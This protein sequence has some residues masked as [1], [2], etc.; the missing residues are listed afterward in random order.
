[1]TSAYNLQPQ[2]GEMIW[3]AGDTMW[4]KA[5]GAET[6]G[7]YTLI[8]NATLP[9]GLLRLSLGRLNLP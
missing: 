6:D 5:T 3:I 1:M 8:E 7:A 2:A 9:A 4:F